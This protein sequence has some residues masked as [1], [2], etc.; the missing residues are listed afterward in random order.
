MLTHEISGKVYYLAN[1][2]CGEYWFLVPP[3]NLTLD[4]QMPDHQVRSNTSLMMT[5]T[6]TP[7]ERGEV[8]LQKLLTQCH[9]CQH[10]L[11]YGLRALKYWE[12]Y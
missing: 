3:A 7:S 6:K 9:I 5:T 12:L 4:K 1:S 11:L 2:R 10:I 8:L